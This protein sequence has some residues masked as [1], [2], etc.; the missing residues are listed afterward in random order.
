MQPSCSRDAAEMQPRCR[1]GRRHSPQTP[2]GGARAAPS[3]PGLDPRRAA[4][5]GRVHGVRRHDHKVRLPPVAR[6]PPRQPLD[7][8]RPFPLSRYVFDLQ[9][10]DVYFCTADC[11]WITG[12]S[13]VTYGP[14]LNGETRPR[15]AA[16]R[17]APEMRRR[18]AAEMRPR[19]VG[20]RAPEGEPRDKACG[21]RRRLLLDSASRLASSRPCR[22][23]VHAPPPLVS[24]ASQLVFEGVPSYPDAGRLWRMVDK[25]TIAQLYTAPT[26]IRALM[27]EGGGAAAGD[28]SETRP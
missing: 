26:A 23:R 13:Y 17:R 15:D 10:G 24:G 8:W 19:R 11:G 27:R 6:L 14:L 2:A 1:K 28:M 21:L 25:Y 12:H 22:R 3:S 20:R 7:S 4:L 5:D 18:D 9:P 16:P